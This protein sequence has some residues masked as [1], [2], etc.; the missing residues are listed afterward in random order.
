[1][2]A[3]VILAPYPRLRM[4]ETCDAGGDRVILDTSEAAGA[5]QCFRQQGEEQAG[6]HAG[7]Q[8]TPPG[9]AQS[10]RGSPESTDDNLRRV[11]GV[12]RRAL[13]GGV[14]LR[15]DSGFECRAGL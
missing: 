10:P 5:A 8:D 12:L 15:R 9:K 1:M 13:E 3:R 2:A 11:M 6:A 7:L 14:F 4:H